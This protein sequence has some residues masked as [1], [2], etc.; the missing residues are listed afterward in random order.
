VEHIEDDSGDIIGELPFEVPVEWRGEYLICLKHE[1]MWRISLNLF[2]CPYSTDA[3]RK[4][5]RRTACFEVVEPFR[6]RRRESSG[7]DWRTRP[8][9][10]MD[11]YIPTPG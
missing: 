11:W 1:C 3:K 9:L 4:A 8:R 10:I 5:A 6:P 7:G 2:G